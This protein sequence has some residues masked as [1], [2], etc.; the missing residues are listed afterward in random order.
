[1]E[2]QMRLHPR[3]KDLSMGFSDIVRLCH[4]Q[5]PNPPSA[6]AINRNITNL[7][8]LFKSKIRSLMVSVAQREG[9]REENDP[10]EEVG[11][12]DYDNGDGERVGDHEDDDDEEDDED[13]DDDYGGTDGS[14]A[15]QGEEDDA[16]GDEVA[17]VL[18]DFDR[19]YNIDTVEFSEEFHRRYV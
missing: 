17:N 2:M 3:Y 5:L 14:P 19:E 6:A 16:V 8:N 10:A 4:E 13:D 12:A 1:M 18:H 15:N 9:D 7:I 11:M